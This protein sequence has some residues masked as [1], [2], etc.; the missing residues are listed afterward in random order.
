[1]IIDERLDTF[2]NSMSWNLP[3]YLKEIEKKALED[4]VPIIRRTMETLLEFLITTRKPVKIL[5]V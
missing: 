2:I 3:D 4:E 5:E 1:M